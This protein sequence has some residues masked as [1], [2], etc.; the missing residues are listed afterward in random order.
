MT[1]LPETM[2]AV[3]ISTPGGPK[4]L[5][6]VMRP[7]PQLKAHEV[8]I[9]VAYAG[10]NRPDCLQRA[11]AY[12]PPP[13]A[14]DLPGLEVSG[15]VVA[16]GGSAKRWTIGHKVCALTPGGGYAEYVAVPEGQIVPVPA[17]LSML[18]AAA[19]PETFFTVWSNVF[20]RGKLKSGETLL[21][22]GGASGIGTTAIMLGIAFGA[23]VIIT[24]GS[25]ARCYACLTLGADNAIN[26]KTQDFVEQ[27]KT[28]T[29]GH[30]ADVILDMV[31]GDYVMR[32]HKCAAV[33]GRIVQ[34]ATLGGAVTEIDLRLVMGKRLTHT[35]S[36]L[37]P[38]SEAAKA[39]IA[40]QLVEHVWPLIEAGTIAPLM[41]EMFDLDLAWQAHTRMEAGEVVGK[42]VL[43]VGG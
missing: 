9:K 23:S 10:V 32:N 2:R 26:Y 13:G 15:E 8:L 21:I 5:L 3:E 12:P 20:M 34:I 37:R 7:L 18:Q 29:T 24:A 19:L 4:V 27:I 31:G 22:H 40:R 38:Q 1:T 14:S 42:M 17:N 16:L 25:D 11:G 39:E 35:G 30:G 28:I 41:D 43:R 36:T 6:P 33:D